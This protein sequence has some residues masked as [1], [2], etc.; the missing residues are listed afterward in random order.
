MWHFFAVNN[1][2]TSLYAD[3]KSKQEQTRTA[4]TGKWLIHND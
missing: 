2:D 3:T 1:S 4:T